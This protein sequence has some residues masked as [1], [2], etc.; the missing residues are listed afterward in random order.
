MHKLPQFGTAGIEFFGIFWLVLEITLVCANWIKNPRAGPGLKPFRNISSPFPHRCILNPLLQGFPNLKLTS[1]TP[2]Q[3]VKN[4][5]VSRKEG[6]SARGITSKIFHIMPCY[7]S[8]KN[9]HWKRQEFPTEPTLTPQIQPA[10]V[11]HT[12]T[13]VISSQSSQLGDLGQYSCQM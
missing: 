13:P 2:I 6:L 7:N 11:V 5:F 3:D 1:H 9:K 12:Y 4:N 8:T 10:Q